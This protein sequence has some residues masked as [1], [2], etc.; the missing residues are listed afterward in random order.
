MV[1]G[2]LGGLLGI[3]GSVIMIPAMVWIFGSIV[4]R[5][6]NVHQYQAA[7][8]IVN[9][10][11]SGSA[12]IRH[13]QAKAIY[14]GVWKYLAPAALVGMALGVGA[15]RLAIFTGSNE[16]YMRMAFGA[17]LLYVAAYNIWKMRGGTSEGISSEEA[18]RVA[19]PKKAGVG[20]PMGFA[21]GLLG[22]GG[23]SFAVP[24]MQLILRLPL[25]NAIATSSVTILSVAW[26]GAIIK[27]ASLGQDGT[28]V[29][30]LVLAGILAPTA[31]IGGYIGGRL[32][33]VL[34]LRIVRIAFIGLMLVA[35]VKMFGWL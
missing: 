7:A 17:L 28:V 2:V 35:A 9:F 34:P 5:P 27:N 13:A 33:Y 26:F 19:W 15:S 22:I 23:G 25:R 32:T 8:M 11:L 1:A 18:D 16:R 24:A 29:R 20:L 6:E 4:A 12:V 3:G 14:P 21:A 31:M 30:S 10:L